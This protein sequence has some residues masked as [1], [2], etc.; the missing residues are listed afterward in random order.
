MYMNVNPVK[1][2]L[3]TYTV[4]WFNSFAMSLAKDVVRIDV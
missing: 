4:T 1:V 3:D 2:S